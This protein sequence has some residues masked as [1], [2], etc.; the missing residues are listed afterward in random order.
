[1]EPLVNR[2]CEWFKSGSTVKAVMNDVTAEWPRVGSH[3]A[4]GWRKGDL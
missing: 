3:K 4:E 1:M 2:G